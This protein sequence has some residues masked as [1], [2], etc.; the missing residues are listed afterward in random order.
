MYRRVR[1]S[2]YIERLNREVKRLSKVVGV[3]PSEVSALRL[4]GAVLM[5]ENDRWAAKR[6]LYYKP[7]LEE[8]EE[9]VPRLREIARAQR[10]LLEAV[11]GEEGLRE[12]KPVANLHTNMDLTVRP[13][14]EHANICQKSGQV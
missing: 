11:W 2:N 1:T 12:D 7:A 5:E 3:F 13:R 14:G 9:R 8:L 4:M 6:G 10:E